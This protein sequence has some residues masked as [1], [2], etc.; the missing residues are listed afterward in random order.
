MLSDYQVILQNGDSNDDTAVKVT[1]LTS[2]IFAD[3]QTTISAPNT[4][5]NKNG[6]H[7]DYVEGNST[8]DILKDLFDGFSYKILFSTIEESKTVCDISKENNFPISST[9][10][11]IKRLKD[12]G[13]L[14][15]DR[16]I[17]NE[18]G[19]K[20]IFYKSKICSLELYLNKTQIR[21]HFNKNE[22][23]LKQ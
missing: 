14:L 6:S 1:S 17:I 7:K 2:S 21:L 4:V 19:K 16:I 22:K 23:N 8:I 15:I 9:Y 12:L 11:K 20:V 10:K 13:L 18:Q 5:V 3:P